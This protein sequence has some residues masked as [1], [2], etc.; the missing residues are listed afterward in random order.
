MCLSTQIKQTGEVGAGEFTK[1]ERAMTPENPPSE[2][3]V[4][5][6]KWGWVV[7]VDGKP[8]LRVPTRVEAEQCAEMLRQAILPPVATQISEL[9]ENACRPGLPA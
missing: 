9:G 6:A 4:R 7:L 5:R 2:I 8:M 3:K 1:K